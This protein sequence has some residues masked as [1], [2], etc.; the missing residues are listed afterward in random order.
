[1]ISC[2]RH[3]YGYRW[4]L[5]PVSMQLYRPRLWQFWPLFK[6]QWIRDRPPPFGGRS[7]RTGW[8]LA[9]PLLSIRWHWRE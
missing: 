9:L 4:H 6:A 8:V 2:Y 1:M 3:E 7:P 5:G